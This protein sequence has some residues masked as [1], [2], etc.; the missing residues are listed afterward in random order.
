MN[1]TVRY[2]NQEYGDYLKNFSYMAVKNYDKIK[3][4]DI[5]IGIE[6]QNLKLQINGIVNKID[7][8]FIYFRVYNINENRLKTIY[9]ENYFIFTKSKEKTNKKED[10]KNTIKN[11]I[12]KIE[13]K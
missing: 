3:T 13:K 8:N 11:F 12:K 7:K 4:G 9:P 5:L 2:I 6:K 1:D 10:F